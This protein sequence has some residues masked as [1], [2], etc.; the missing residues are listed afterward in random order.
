MKKIDADPVDT[1]TINAVKHVANECT[2]KDNVK[3]F[4]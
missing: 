1:I 2:P 4:K 3:N